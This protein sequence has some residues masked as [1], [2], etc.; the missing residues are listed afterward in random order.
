MLAD[1]SQSRV[2]QGLSPMSIMD[3]HPSPV[4]FKMES[5]FA[6]ILAPLILQL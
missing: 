3:P 2:Q 5:A 4:D 1:H 6:F